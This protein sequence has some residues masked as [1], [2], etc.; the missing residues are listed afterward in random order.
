[1]DNNYNIK[2]Y[3]QFNRI[4]NKFSLV[5]RRL[6][7][8]SNCD[9]LYPAEMQVLCL[10]SSNPRFTVTDIAT[11]L[12]ITKSATSQLVKKL[13]TKG[14]LEK[15][16][17]PENERFVFLTITDKGTSIIKNFFE[18]ESHAFG[19]LIKDFSGISEDE[20]ETVKNFLNRLEKMLDKKLQ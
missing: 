10:I 17:L 11:N 16:R 8:D 18:N 1:M 4:N 13:C 14:I 7:E 5:K 12:C 19:E 6:V 2:L 20:L 9:N 3:N 15:T